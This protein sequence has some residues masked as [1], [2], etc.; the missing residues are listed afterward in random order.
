MRSPGLRLAVPLAALALAA[1][2]CG[3][4]PEPVGALPSFPR[5]AQDGQGRSVTMQAQPTRIVSLDPGLTETAFA[6]GAGDD[7]VAASGGESYPAAARRLPVALGSD[8]RPDPNRI[9]RL[10]PDLI[11]APAALAGEATSI[12]GQLHVP[13]YVGG[14]GTVKDIEHDVAQVGV[15]T[16]FAERGRTLVQNMQSRIGAIR[17]AVGQEPPVRVFVDNGFFYTIDPN[18]PAGDLIALAGGVDVAADAEPGKPYPLSKLR[19]AKP[20]AYLALTGRG[21]TLAGLRKSPATKHLPAVRS[22]R[23]LLIDPTALT[24]H[25]PRV[26]VTLREIAHALHPSA[27][28]GA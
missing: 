14:D 22:G 10:R 5:R 7:V 21:T 8:G 11:L 2:A 6:V 12:A 15:L 16:G 26:V 23:F 4:K 13:V 25:G 9:R 24:D 3:M 20:Q 28:L 18:G 17:N 1:P 19:A 27:P